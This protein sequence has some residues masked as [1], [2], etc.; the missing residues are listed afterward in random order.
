M[1]AAIF[2]CHLDLALELFISQC[3]TN[4]AENSSVFLLSILVLVCSDLENKKKKN[5][6]LN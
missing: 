1:L 3:C 4:V 2:H 5:D 6:F